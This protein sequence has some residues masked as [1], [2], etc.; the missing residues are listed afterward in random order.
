MNH[1]CEEGQKLDLMNTSTFR[2]TRVLNFLG[3]NYQDTPLPPATPYVVLFSSREK[4]EEAGG[5]KRNGCVH[6]PPVFWWVQVRSLGGE[7]G[8]GVDQG[9]HV[10]SLQ[11]PATPSPVGLG[12]GQH[13]M[14]EASINCTFWEALSASGIY[15]LQNVFIIQNSVSES[16]SWWMS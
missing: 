14:W 7:G 11:G 6:R 4:S 3:L 9:L 1:L 16:V 15:H 12:S 5:G 2:K 10:L 8:M 13:I